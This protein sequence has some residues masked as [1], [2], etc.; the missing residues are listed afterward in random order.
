MQFATGDLFVFQ[1]RKGSETHVQPDLFANK[2]GR[3]NL[4]QKARGEVQTRG[5][6]GDRLRIIASEL[7]LISI[8]IFRIGW[9]SPGD[10]RRQWHG[11][12]GIDGGVE[13]LTRFREPQ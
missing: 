2:T 12:G 5:G 8:A 1:R 10:V 13:R 11:P 6:C 7:R 9:A 4:C 3:L